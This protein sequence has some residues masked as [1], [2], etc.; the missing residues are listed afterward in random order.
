MYFFVSK[1]ID[2][3]LQPSI[4]PISRIFPFEMKL[5]LLNNNPFLFSPLPPPP[6]LWQ[7][8]LYCVPVRIY[9]SH[10]SGITQGFYINVLFYLS[11]CLQDFHMI[12]YVRISFLI[13][14]HILLYLY[15]Y[16][17]VKRYLGYIFLT[18][19]E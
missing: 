12:G 19:Y 10:M 5:Y 6:L 1:Y 7:P 18:T 8:L 2:I 13:F 3:V 4:P 15:I 16:S 17:S 9:I 11:K 14:D